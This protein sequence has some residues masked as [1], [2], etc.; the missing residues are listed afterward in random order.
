MLLDVAVDGGLK[1]DDRVEHTAFEA[2]A[3]ERREE[4]LDG[5]DPG[6][7]LWREVE[8][9]ARMA[10][11]PSLNLGVL[12]G[13]VVVDDGMDGFAGRDGALD[14]IEETNEL[15]VAVALHAAA[16]DGAIEH[17]E[18]REQSGGATPFRSYEWEFRSER[19]RLSMWVADDARLFREEF[20]RATQSLTVHIENK[21]FRANSGGTLIA[22]R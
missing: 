12:V 4:A 15:L 11:E 5:V 13:G 2:A 9:P 3:R 8:D 16:E 21:L 22:E 7:G 18:R 19:R 6:A 17:V 14:R 1:V 10:S 20:D